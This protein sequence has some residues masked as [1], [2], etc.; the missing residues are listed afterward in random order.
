MDREEELMAE[1]QILK[2]NKNIRA[3]H[4]KNC[5]QQKGCWFFESKEVNITRASDCP[6]Y[7]RKWWKFWVTEII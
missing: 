2:E 6:D 5:S 4:C 1:E 7:K 3:V